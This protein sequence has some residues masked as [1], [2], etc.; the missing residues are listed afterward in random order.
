[1]AYSIKKGSELIRVGAVINDGKKVFNGCLG[2]ATQEELNELHSL[3]IATNH[4][5]IT[6]KKKRPKKKRD[7]SPGEP[8]PTPP[9]DE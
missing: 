9:K 5:K 8:T 2:D 1:M 6:T 3:G 7:N 4:I